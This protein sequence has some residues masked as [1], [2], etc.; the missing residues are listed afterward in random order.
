[1]RIEEQEELYST[2]LNDFYLLHIQVFIP[3]KLLCGDAFVEVLD[4]GELL[5]EEVEKFL[6]NLYVLCILVSLP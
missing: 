1:M 5:K 6:T 4:F 2:A 3:Q